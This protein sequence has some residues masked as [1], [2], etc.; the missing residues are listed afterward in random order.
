[1]KDHTLVMIVL[2]IDLLTW[3]FLL[4]HLVPFYVQ[5]VDARCYLET[6]MQK[7]GLCSSLS[8]TCRCGF[9]YDVY[10]SRMCVKAYDVNRRMIYTMRS[11]GQGFSGM[12]KF[13]ALMNMQKP[14]TVKNYDRSAASIPEVCKAVAQET[15][16][17]AVSELKGYLPTDT[18]N[19]V[20]VSVNPYRRPNLHLYEHY[21]LGCTMR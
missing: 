18:M 12:Q 3:S 5:N 20:G 17:D 4:K 16:N 21:S 11:L 8:L 15:M 10:T 7:Y 6:A 2:D 14:M 9:V 13:T 1:M 19:D